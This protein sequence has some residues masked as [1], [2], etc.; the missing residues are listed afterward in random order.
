MMYGSETWA[1]PSTVMDRLDCAERKLLRWLLGYFCRKETGRFF[2]E[3]CGVCSSWNKP[4]GRKL[5]KT[6][7]KFW[8]DVVKEDLRTLGVNRQFRRDKIEKV[9]MSCVQGRYTS[10]KITS[11]DDISPPI[12]R[13]LVALWGYQLIYTDIQLPMIR[14][15]TSERPE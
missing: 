14:V 13:S 7:W 1:A 12:S 10:A 9:G 5:T 2:N 11:G 4:P 8:T 15:P 6:N 3:F